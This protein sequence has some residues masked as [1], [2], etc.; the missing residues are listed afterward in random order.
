MKCKECNKEF[1]WCA[2]CGSDRNSEAKACSDEC[3]E[4][5]MEPHKKE[6]KEFIRSLN[7]KQLKYAVD[8]LE[9]YELE[10]IEDYV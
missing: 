10:F 8:N 7:P 9:H 4:K 1:H 2:S 6:L 3:Y 5:I